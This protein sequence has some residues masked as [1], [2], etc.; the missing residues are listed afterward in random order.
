M[1]FIY[2]DIYKDIY[3]DIYCLI[4]RCCYFRMWPEHDPQGWT[5]LFPLRRRIAA[6]PAILGD[7]AVAGTPFLKQAKLAQHAAMVRDCGHG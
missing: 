2:G 6:S 4:S 5:A 1:A 3:R 7:A